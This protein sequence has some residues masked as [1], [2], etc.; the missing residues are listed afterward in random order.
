MSG[1]MRHSHIVDAIVV[2]HLQSHVRSRHSVA[3]RDFRVL[4]E[5]VLKIHLYQPADDGNTDK[6][7]PLHSYHSCSHNFLSLNCE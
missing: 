7:N 2:Q 1:R 4:L 5:F 6:N 3:G